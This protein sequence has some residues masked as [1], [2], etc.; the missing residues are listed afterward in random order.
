MGKDKGIYV[1]RWRIPSV[2]HQRFPL[3]L[4]GT[5]LA[6]CL[7]TP[8]VARAECG[9]YVTHG[10][11]T[12]RTSAQSAPSESRAPMKPTQPQRSC[13]G[14]HCSQGRPAPIV[15]FRVVPE[16]LEQWGWAGIAPLSVEAKAIEFIQETFWQHPV[17]A[18]QA[19]Y[20]PPR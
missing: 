5:F 13:R 3:V 15:P 4:L 18:A 19:I 10:T 20:H 9:D 14:P 11:A 8:S 16:K 6:L 17:H 12:S 7:V 1:A 2:A